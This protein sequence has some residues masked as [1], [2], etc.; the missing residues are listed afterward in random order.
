M[1]VDKIAG[2]SAIAPEDFLGQCD[3]G[4]SLLSVETSEMTKFRTRC[5]EFIDRLAVLIVESASAKSVVSK[6]L[7][8]FCPEL[9]LEGDDNAAFALFSELCRVLVRCNAIASDEAKA[10]QDEYNSY[11][12]EKGDSIVV[13][14]VLLVTFRMCVVIC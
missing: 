4:K 3:F 14:N 7:Y 8:S 9:M 11:I 2:F 6:G 1:D 10:A 13:W 5:R 12:I